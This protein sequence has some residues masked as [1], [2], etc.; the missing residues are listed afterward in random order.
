[1]RLVSAIYGDEFPFNHLPAV[2][3]C[4][5]SVD[6]NI[7][8][9][10]DILLVWGGQ[11]ISPALYNKPKSKYSGA[12]D[13]SQ[14]DRI[15]WEFMNR[16]KAFGVP[17]IGVCRGAQMLCALAGGHLL[18]HV[19]SHGR[20]HVVQTPTGYEF[21]TNSC[22]HQMMYPFDVKH[23][24]LAS[25]KVPIAHRHL[26][27]DNE[28]VVPEEPECVWFPEVKGFAVQWHPEWMDFQCEATQFVLKSITERL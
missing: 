16:A 26:E 27:V 15:E 6:P 18:Q 2:D 4:V 3:Q 23:E 9:D 17:I 10:G 25:I 11:D 19:D 13:N 7:I 24:M 5:A 22:H 28:V 12:D 8:K 20:N 14:R 1:M 21:Q